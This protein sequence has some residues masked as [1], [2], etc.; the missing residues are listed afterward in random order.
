M[1]IIPKIIAAVIIVGSITYFLYDVIRH[2]KNRGGSTK[3]IIF[4]IL[5][6][7]MVFIFF[8]I[9]NLLINADSLS[10]KWLIKF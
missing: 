3:D 4:R 9:I 10:S 6:W 5:I 1:N 7:I 8:L 2:A